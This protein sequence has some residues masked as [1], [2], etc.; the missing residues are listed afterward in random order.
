MD[1]NLTPC[2][3]VGDFLRLLSFTGFRCIGVSIGTFAVSLFFVFQLS[4][5]TAFVA[6]DLV[7]MQT[8]LTLPFVIM[9]LPFISCLE[10]GSCFCPLL[11][12]CYIQLLNIDCRQ[13]VATYIIWK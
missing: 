6:T 5:L 1:E 11:Y 4:S 9:H 7:D 2:W 12:S 8:L 3:R 10:N 13:Q